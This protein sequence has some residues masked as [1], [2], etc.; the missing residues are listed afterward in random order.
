MID[1]YRGDVVMVDFPFGEGRGSKERPAVIV[2]CDADIRRLDT[3]LVAMVTSKTQ[4]VGREPRHVLI[5][6]NSDD[7]R[8]TGLWMNS[9]VNCTQLAAIKK[10]LFSKRLGALPDA[11]MESV[12]N[13]LRGTMDL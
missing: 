1:L 4:R 12:S 7:G 2:Q 9:V 8:A 6:V 3:I 5:D 11:L 10:K 13:A